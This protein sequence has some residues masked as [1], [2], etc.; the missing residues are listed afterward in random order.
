MKLHSLLKL[1]M[2]NFRAALAL[3]DGPHSVCGVCFSLCLNKSTPYLSLCLSLNSFCDETSRTWASLGPE[4]RHCVFKSQSVVNGFI[5]IR[6]GSGLNWGSIEG[7]RRGW[8]RMRW[9]DGITDSMNM[10]LS[11]LWKLVMDREAWG[12]TQFSI[13]TTRGSSQLRNWIYLLHWQADSLSMSH[14]GSLHYVE[15]LKLMQCCMSIESKQKW[16]GWGWGRRENV[17]H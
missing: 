14:Q 13:W 4:T 2:P 7:R 8:Q 3:C 11:K 10:S 1:T 12:Q 16:Q 9:L 15:H 6:Q 17:Q 5:R